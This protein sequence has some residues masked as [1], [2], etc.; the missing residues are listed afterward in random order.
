MSRTRIVSL[1]TLITIIFAQNA[2]PSM[3]AITVAA[4][5]RD[6][7]LLPTNEALIS[8]L[9]VDP[10]NPSTLYAGFYYHGVYK[11]IDGGG[12][13]HSTNFGT[14]T[15]E[16]HITDIAIDPL[17]PDTVFV[18]GWDGVYKT[19]DGGD[20]WLNTMP[21]TNTYVVAIDPITTTNVYAGGYYHVYKSIDGGESWANT[22]LHSYISSSVIAM[23]INPVDPSIVYAATNYDGIY[24]SMNG[25]VNWSPVND[26][27]T[28]LQIQDMDIDRLAPATL[29]A[30]SYQGGIFKSENGGENWFAVNNGIPTGMVPRAIAVDPLTPSTLYTGG[31]KQGVYKSINGGSSWEAMNGGLDIKDIFSIAI[32]PLTSST[33]YAGTIDGIYRSATGGNDWGPA[34]YGI[35]NLFAYSVAIDPLSPDVRYEGTNESVYKTTDGGESGRKIDTN[36]APQFIYALA[37]DPLNP[38]IV[39]AGT[40]YGLYKSVNG[41]DSWKH[42]NN[43]YPVNVVAIN[44]IT[45]TIVYAGTSNGLYRSLNGG[46]D[47]TTL[48][49]GLPVNGNFLSLAIAPANPA[50][51]YTAVG[52]CSIYKTTDN[53]D[54]WNV[55]YEGIP[56]C[57]ELKLAIDPTN[58]STIYAA[59]NQEIWHCCIVGYWLKS[60]DGGENWDTI[61]YSNFGSRLALI[62]DPQVPSTLYLADDF[63]VSMSIDGGDHWENI[64]HSPTT[65]NAFAIKPHTTGTVYA[66]TWGRGIVG[67]FTRKVYIPMAMAPGQR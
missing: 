60:S 16:I 4:K 56:D 26:G 2:N 61:H 35:T 50:T 52:G 24:M 31:W 53:G 58:A 36:L 49:G 3:L 22:D 54:V 9:V 46:S 28:V 67:I 44:P 5:D 39:F 8:T 30:A 48:E 6:N 64:P 33:I 21:Y 38:I 23:S 10:T 65:V 12:G 66:A 34:G 7:N 55:V 27:L 18:V 45:T 59:V 11:S 19:E 14:Y 63:G 62:V 41:G 13:W 40:D 37:I 43:E 32:D 15:G 25:G 1:L 42:I 57:W 47:W 29:Y 17:T 51:V 20:T